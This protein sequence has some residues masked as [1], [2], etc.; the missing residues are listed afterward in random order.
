MAHPTNLVVQVLLNLPMVAKLEDLLQALYFYFSNSLERHLEFIK[1]VEILE[2][3]GLKILQNV[4]TRWISMLK[5]FKWVMAKYKTLIVKM[6]RE[7]VSVAQ[8]RFDLNL[9]CHLHMLLGLFCLLP[10]LEAVNALIKFAQRRDVF[11]C[12]FVATVEICQVDLYMMY[13]D[14]LLLL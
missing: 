1:L 6:S 13:S 7:N 12:D 9:L 3:R 8:A 14:L 11:I 2:I 10:L 5:P 4:K